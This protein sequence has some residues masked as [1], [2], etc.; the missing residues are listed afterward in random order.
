MKLKSLFSALLLGCAMMAQA[1]SANDPTIMTING[2]PISRSE[3]EY[4]YNKNNSEGVIDKKSVEEYVD[5]FINY[6]LKVQAAIDAKM[7]TMPAYKREF[8]N[9]RDQQIRPTIINDADVE[10]EAYK[11]YKETQERIDGAGGM[12]QVS[13]ILIMVP[14]K[15]TAEEMMADSARADSIYSAIMKGSDFNEMARRYSADKASVAKGGQLNWITKG[16]T[17]PTFENAAYSM[18]PGEI[19]RPVKSPFGW[20]II[21]MD[22]QRNF[23]EYD[24]LK[25]DIMKFIEMRGLR[26]KIINDKLDSLA[27]VQNTTPEA[28]LDQRL[29][30]ME[31]KDP[32]LKNLVREYHDGLLLFEVSNRTIWGKA[33]SDEA[34]L[35]QYFK[36]HKKQYKWDEPRFKGMAY[37]VKD[38]AD[39]AAVRNAVKGLPF[40][41]WA[42]KLR[43]TFNNDSVI[44][45]RVEKGIFKKGDNPLVDRNEF[46]VNV[47]VTPTKD[48]PIDA[49][50]GKMIKAPEEMNDVRGQVTADYQ[51]L[52][53]E[54]WVKELRKKY[55]VVINRE[56]LAT[57]NK[58]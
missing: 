1:Q 21:R 34:G 25:A 9:Y 45:I 42:D 35:L 6:K 41:D 38:E 51:N 5:L 22:G 7:D 15:A 55:P 46:K 4:S 11:I 47:N 10:A 16:Q 52:L 40:G 37:H 48:Y 31:A 27:K 36:K 56:V 2:Q 19:S 39:V 49:T 8:L 23:F 57:V 17:V 13:H 32:D 30:E 28:I 12:R 58:H 53:E 14:P 43:S 18:R 54:Q 24:S 44:R 50:Y 33:A 20:H 3:F 26:E 29:V